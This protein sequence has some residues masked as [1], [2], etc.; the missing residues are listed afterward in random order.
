M[1]YY[2]RLQ[3]RRLNHKLTELGFHPIIGDAIAL[4]TFFGLSYYLYFKTEY[5]SY[6]Y[7]SLAIISIIPLSEPKRN[8]FLKLAFPNSTYRKIRLIEN[9]L[10]LS[11]FL[12]FLIYYQD[13]WIIFGLSSIGI[14]L[15]YFRATNKFQWEFPTPF[16]KVPFEFPIGYRRW[17]LALLFAYFITIMALSVGN[18]NLGIFSLILVFLICLSFYGNPELEYFVWVF[19]LSPKQFLIHKAKIALL[20]SSILSFPIL[21]SI[22]VAFPEGIG[23]ILLFQVLGYIY[24]ITMI[25]AK[26][27]AFPEQINVPQGILIA[28]SFWMPPMLVIVIPILYRQ[29]IRRLNIYLA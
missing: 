25:L 11:L 17:V 6:I 5:A 7:A 23:L 24:V 14:G 9:V 16:S 13:Y 27:S 19:A 29:A 28:L 20:G 2:F 4:C 26:Y 18:Y 1:A 12:P 3:F 22:S 10:V 15:S 21:I 8:D